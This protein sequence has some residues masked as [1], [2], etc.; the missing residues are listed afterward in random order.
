MKTFYL[1]LTLI[2]FRYRIKV[3]ELA[4]LARD[5]PMTGLERAIW[6]TEYVIRHKGARHLR[7]P[8]LD[9]P[10]Y[11]FYLLDVIG[12]VVAS[13]IGTIFLIYFIIKLVIKIV[14]ALFIKR[15]VKQ[16]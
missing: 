1:Q 7:S 2:F 14:R 11:Q 4:E 15:K 3:K 8:A 16:Q 5:Q 12:F 10:W 13:L 9:L 6:W